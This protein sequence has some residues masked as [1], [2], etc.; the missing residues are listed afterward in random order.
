MDKGYLT[1]VLKKATRLSGS[2]NPD[3]KSG[4]TDYL[5]GDPAN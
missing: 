2:P 5:K 1:M 3:I 4:Q